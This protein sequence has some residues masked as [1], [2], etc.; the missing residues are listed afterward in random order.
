[1][2]NTTKP[3]DGMSEIVSQT[4]EQT[5][6]AME[7]Y[8]GALQ[9]GMSA[10]PW[11]KTDLT[12]ATDLTNKVKTYIEQNIAAASEYIKNLTEAKTLEDVV[13]HQTEFLQAQFKS[14]AEQA[15]D[16]GETATKT[17]TNAINSVIN[18]PS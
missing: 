2:D 6:T 5:R 1:M 12:P 15:R 11:L 7:H 4:I 3:F 16:L 14:F 10:A 17:A 18:P 8:F 9:K 13:K